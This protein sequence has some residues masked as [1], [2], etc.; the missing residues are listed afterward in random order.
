MQSMTTLRETWALVLYV[1]KKTKTSQPTLLTY[2]VTISITK[3][4][5]IMNVMSKSKQSVW[6]YMEKHHIYS[7]KLLLNTNLKQ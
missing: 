6:W 3:L 4:S 1:R 2:F 7:D 5:S